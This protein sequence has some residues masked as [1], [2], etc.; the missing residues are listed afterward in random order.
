M[1]IVFLINRTSTS[2]LHGKSPYERLFNKLLVLFYVQVLGCL[3]YALSIPK[4][5]DKFASRSLRRV[6]QGI[7]QEKGMEGL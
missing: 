4:F 5:K 3:F 2:L 6:F 1:T 7:P